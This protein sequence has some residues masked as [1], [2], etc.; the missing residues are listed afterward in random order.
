MAAKAS[1][2]GSLSGML[3]ER[4]SQSGRAQQAADMLGA[5]WRTAL[6]ARLPEQFS[7][8]NHDVADRKQRGKSVR[9]AIMRA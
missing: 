5:E 3:A 1:S 7:R 6:D 4:L 2:V 9:K 8:Y